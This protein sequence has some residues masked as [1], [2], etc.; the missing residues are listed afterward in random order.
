[1]HGLFDV[2]FEQQ[3]YATVLPVLNVSPPSNDGCYSL[4]VYN[5]V[6][7]ILSDPAEYKYSKTCR[8]SLAYCEAKPWT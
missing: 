6:G 5:I 4:G 3:N 2:L 8:K 1:M 7:N